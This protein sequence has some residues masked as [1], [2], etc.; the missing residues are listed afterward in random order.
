MMP[1]GQGFKNG[2]ADFLENIKEPQYQRAAESRML[3]SAFENWWKES[4]AFDLHDLIDDTAFELRDAWANHL[5]RF[6]SNGLTGVDWE[7]KDGARA[8]SIESKDDIIMKYTKRLLNRKDVAYDNLYQIS[9][10]A[11]QALVDA[12]KDTSLKPEVR[13]LVT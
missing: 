8:R 9:V 7:R 2:I 10:R 4:A 1:P 3:Q 11:Q 6:I 12:T 13:A 5:I